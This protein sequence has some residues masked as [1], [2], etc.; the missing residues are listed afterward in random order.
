MK[1]E[2]EK[3]HGAVELMVPLEWERFPSVPWDLARG[4]SSLRRTRLGE[5]ARPPPGDLVPIRRPK[6]QWRLATNSSKLHKIS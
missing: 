4:S 2:P 5:R 1:R 3:E 6:W